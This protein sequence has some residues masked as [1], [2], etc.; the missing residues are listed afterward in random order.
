MSEDFDLTKHVEEY[1][2]Y[3]QGPLMSSLHYRLVLDI[4]RIAQKAGILPKFICTSMTKWCGDEERE[5]VRTL[6]ANTSEGIAGL[7]YLGDVSDLESRMMA[8]AGAC[9]RNYINA[10]LMTL[11]DVVAMISD[12][13]YPDCQVL[14]I[15]NFSLKKDEGGSVPAW[16]VAPLLGLIMNRYSKGKQTVVYIQHLPSM[17][18]MYGKIMLDHITEHYTNLDFGG[19]K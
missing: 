2:E 5:W 3:Y 10:R 11:Q 6:K 16:Q 15:P 8:I 4:E 13:D 12:G 17:R 7:A 19:G 18:A 14:L 9:I 1:K